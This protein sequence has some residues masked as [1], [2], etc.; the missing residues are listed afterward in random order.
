MAAAPRRPNPLLQ[1]VLALLL[2]SGSGAAAEPPKAPQI[3]ENA[4]ALATVTVPKPPELDA[5]TKCLALAIYWEGRAE[6]REG[7]VA[8]A[9]TVLNR[10]GHGEF[11]DSICGVV[12]QKSAGGKSCQ[13]SW[14]CDGKQDIPES[15]DQ[16]DNS[17]EVARE[18]KDRTSDDPTKG[19]LFFH[20]VKVDPNWDGKRERIGRIGDHIFYR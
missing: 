19:A 4:A 12:A 3:E 8:I 15:K 1:F 10:V 11:P 13:F 6:S 17:V 7:Q 2:L 9:H 18:A 5:E 20:S 16:W 14:W